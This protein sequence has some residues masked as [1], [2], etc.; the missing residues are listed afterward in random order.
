MLR[1]GEL[2]VERGTRDET[3]RGELN[4]GVGDRDREHSCEWA[5]G[6][7]GFCPCCCCWLL[8][9]L[10]EDVVDGCSGLKCESES[11]PVTIGSAV[12][13]LAKVA[14]TGLTEVDVVVDRAADDVGTNCTGG[15]GWLPA[16]EPERTSTGEV[17][18][19]DVMVE[20]PSGSVRGRERSSAAGSRARSGTGLGGARRVDGR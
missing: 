2:C 17:V 8:L 18:R 1:V 5:S 19:R 13:L 20:R 11:K 12:R 15:W 3:L 10:E 9:S 6:G 16:P 14:V 7:D 4:S